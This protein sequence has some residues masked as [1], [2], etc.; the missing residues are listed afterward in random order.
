MTA[1]SGKHYSC[2]EWH[3][4][5]DTLTR[6]GCP[7]SFVKGA[8]RSAFKAGAQEHFSDCCLDDTHAVPQEQNLYG[9]PALLTMPSPSN[10]LAKVTAGD[11]GTGSSWMPWQLDMPTRY[12]TRASLHEGFMQHGCGSK[13]HAVETM[14]CIAWRMNRTWQAAL[15]HIWPPRKRSQAN[16]LIYLDLGANAPDTS[17]LTFTEQYPSGQTFEVI[18][19]EAAPEW[20]PHYRPPLC[21]TSCN[22]IQAAVGVNDTTSYL[23]RASRS[24]H[25][26]LGR[27]ISQHPDDRSHVVPVQTVD[28]RRWLVEN[29]RHE[30]LVVC[31]MDIEKSEFDV[32]PALLREPSVLR[33]INELFVEC[34]HLETWDN[35]PHRRRE[36]LHLF[37]QLLAAGVWTH[38]WY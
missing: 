7:S 33:L 18:A 20:G 17:M 3:A 30:D 28:L 35:G 26:S 12:A 15:G 27:D 11:N 36:C 38:D 8:A 16:R 10:R 31:K 22:N 34:H 2:K 13:R 19:F 37:E 21:N 1:L 29:V 5:L 14:R 25:G 23:S 6:P 4:G 9:A 32:L 24:V